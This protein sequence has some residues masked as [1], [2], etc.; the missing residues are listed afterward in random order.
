[1]IS[2]IELNLNI[3]KM[4]LQTVLKIMKKDYGW[5]GELLKEQEDFA[6]DLIDA[7]E[8]ALIIDGV[9]NWVAVTEKLPL[10]DGFYLVYIDGLTEDKALYK[11][12]E[13]H[14]RDETLMDMEITHWMYLPK[15]PCC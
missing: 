10:V 3:T 4:N 12:N 14:I 8:K 13:F 11:N 9:S 7:A 2:V 1:M 5:S 6:Q 15:P